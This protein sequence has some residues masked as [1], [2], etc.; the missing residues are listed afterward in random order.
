MKAVDTHNIPPT[1]KTQTQWICWESEER[2]GEET[3]LPRAPWVGHMGNVSATDWVNW[4]TF[5][6]AAEWAHRHPKLGL[7]YVF[8]CAGPYCGVDLD[9]CITEANGEK[10]LKPS[11]VDILDRLGSYAEYSPSGEGLHIIVRASLDDALKNESQGVEVYDRNRFFTFTGDWL[12]Q[13]K[14]STF[15]NPRQDEIDGLVEQYMTEEPQEDDG[16]NDYKSRDPLA[17]D[18]SGDG[19]PMYDLT[20]ADVYPGEPTDQNFDHPVHGSTSL[21]GNFKI[22]SNSPAATCWRGK[23]QDGGEPGCTL[24]A[25]HLLAMEGGGWDDCLYVRKNYSNAD[26][27]V[28]EAWREAHSR[29]LV[30]GKHPPWRAVVHIGV[31]EWG[32]ERETFMGGEDAQVMFKQVCRK[33]R[34]EYDIPVE[35]DD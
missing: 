8:C 21:Q 1:M 28:F 22:H 11:A 35:I 20:V 12:G 26:E 3:K 6:T 2:D 34:Y 25:W 23:H 5:E 9:H 24:C 15:A 27:M 31:S 33:I 29:G 16:D 4:A 32:L 30:S 7:G 14:S 13:E 19:H 17:G 18:I 10:R